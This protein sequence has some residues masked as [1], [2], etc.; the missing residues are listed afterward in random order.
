MW[1]GLQLLH[2]HPLASL[3]HPY[4]PPNLPARPALLP[5]WWL[6][7][8]VAGKGSPHSWSVQGKRC[9]ELGTDLMGTSCFW[10]NFTWLSPS[11]RAKWGRFVNSNPAF[12]Y[13]ESP[14]GTSDTSHQHDSKLLFP[15]IF[16]RR[17]YLLT[18]PTTTL[19]SDLQQP[20]AR[21]AHSVQTAGANALA[22]CCAAPVKTAQQTPV[23]SFWS[24]LGWLLKYNDMEKWE[25]VCF[26]KTSIQLQSCW[27]LFII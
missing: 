2:P 16:W 23:K 17:C 1:Q 27:D 25:V 18:L 7:K 3:L 13:P 20:A 6:E 8:A 5:R 11:T 26:R 21:A 15:D 14:R 9:G 19:G 10:H 22:P 12:V 24:A 4:L